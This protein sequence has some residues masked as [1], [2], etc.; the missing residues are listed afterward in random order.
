VNWR[1]GILMGACVAG[2]LV[3]NL[4]VLDSARPIQSAGGCCGYRQREPMVSD[5]RIRIV[6]RRRV[7]HNRL[8]NGYP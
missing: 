1:S 6:Q 2:G 5:C 7:S 3:L 8:D 4:M